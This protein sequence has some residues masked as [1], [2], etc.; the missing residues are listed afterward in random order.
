MHEGNSSPRSY[1]EVFVADL[2]TT[3][4]QAIAKG[5]TAEDVVNRRKLSRLP[6]M[7][8][9]PKIG[10]GLQLRW[11]L[12]RAALRRRVGELHLFSATGSEIIQHV[13]PFQED[14]FALKYLKSGSNKSDHDASQ[15]RKETLARQVSDPEVIGRL[16]ELLSRRYGATYQR[17]L[18]APTLAVECFMTPVHAPDAPRAFLRFLRTG[19]IPLANDCSRVTYVK[20]LES[21]A[22]DV[23][24][25]TALDRLT[26]PSALPI[27][28]IAMPG[29]P[30]GQCAVAHEL[31]RRLA[32]RAKES[33]PILLLPCGRQFRNSHY[34]GLSFLVHNL[35]AFLEQRPLTD[36]AP[37][38]STGELQVA[39]HR[40]R[41]H[42]CRRAIIV[43]LVGYEV[44][45]GL[46]PS[47][48]R[49]IRDE[50]LAQL[51]P[52]MIQP[53]VGD[54]D[55]PTIIHG[56]FNETRWVVFSDEP[57]DLLEPYREPTIE[58]PG[59]L[60]EQAEEIVTM[61]TDDQ[62]H[63]RSLVDMS[64]ASPIPLSEAKIC[65]AL[66]LL[67][68]RAGTHE[69][70]LSLE[71]FVGQGGNRL[72]TL[73]AESVRRSANPIEA[74]ALHLLALAGS[75]LRYTT[76]WH[77]L[78]EWAHADHE[79]RKVA[80]SHLPTL[81]QAV[82]WFNQ[83]LRK[84]RLV[85]YDGIDEAEPSLDPL[86]HPFEY[87]TQGVASGL[88]QE[89]AAF[90]RREGRGAYVHKSLDFRFVELRETLSD[91]IRRHSAP[92]YACSLHRVLATEALR[93][94]GLLLRHEPPEYRMGLRDERRAL[95]G[96]YHG[97]LSLPSRPEVVKRAKLSS[98]AGPQ[99][100]LLSEPLEAFQ[101]LRS[102]V[103]ARLLE[104]R[105]QYRLSLEWAAD[106]IK[107]DILE[108]FHQ[109]FSELPSAPRG[110]D[111]VPVWKLEPLLPEF[112]AI[113]REHA[114][115]VAVAAYGA[116]DGARWDGFYAMIS[117]LEAGGDDTLRLSR[118]NFDMALLRIGPLS[119]E[120]A[121]LAELPLKTLNI[122]WR[123]FAAGPWQSPASSK[124][125]E[126]PS[127]G[128]LNDYLVKLVDEVVKAAVTTF[129][130]A[131]NV[132]N[133]QAAE[134]AVA[135][136]SALQWSEV[137]DW[138]MRL[139]ELRY[140]HA[141]LVVRENDVLRWQ[142]TMECFA[143][144]F[145]AARVRAISLRFN[146][147]AATSHLSARGSRLSVRAILDLIRLLARTQKEHPHR[148]SLRNFLV[149]EARSIL[150]AYALT[151]GHCAM[152]CVGML[153][154]ESRYARVVGAEGSHRAMRH[155]IALEFLEEAEARLLPMRTRHRLWLRYL[156]EHCSVLRGL[157]RDAASKPPNLP[158][159]T[160][161][162]H[163]AMFD[164]G[165]LE[166]IVAAAYPMQSKQTD[167]MRALAGAWHESA[168]RQ[169]TLTLQAAQEMGLSLG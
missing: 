150:D 117:G 142:R 44:T 99:V 7:F 78:N 1:D 95:E 23:K 111:K 128:I 85:V 3:L 164:V 87:A 90:D 89:L 2:W 26:D 157:A 75:G 81:N 152:D 33:R 54:I 18:G 61:F 112:D 24:F 123:R 4:C 153:I 13:G 12:A 51:L 59:P 83:I 15:G 64:N 35:L 57:L 79:L 165:Q 52:Y 168:K 116:N 103:F 98:Y 126:V 34:C 143:L 41:E 47:L 58:M 139:G 94:Y 127:A 101:F 102:V 8:W 14:F 5:E 160:R 109:A 105:D 77:C 137:S 97:L 106:D 133:E 88:Q 136:I 162:L 73:F 114:Q 42:L 131:E 63:I 167:S 100:T 108:L 134:D 151:R 96:L 62:R 11:N 70:T 161:L 72:L 36:E 107:L 159:A 19:E 91:D 20:Y 68:L 115:S 156:I 37:S 29:S 40:I 122:D 16:C 31:M 92:W 124:V 55:A 121:D 25:K 49:A 104:R 148:S 169:R 10:L 82:N 113:F 6:G 66:Q 163:L 50:P 138:L 154:L 118:I 56:G 125:L 119:Q 17:S 149:V 120:T 132:V 48:R 93:Q 130:K 147:L 22:R 46:Q 76:L 60:V 84:Y 30:S 38:L 53:K 141:Q 27:Q 158:L 74:A 43:I 166:R 145:V 155:R 32:L 135:T 86:T 28:G 65:T 39:M 110:F 144:T 71:E 69:E 80:C 9:D 140:Q 146:A 129:A 21:S 67:E 45:R